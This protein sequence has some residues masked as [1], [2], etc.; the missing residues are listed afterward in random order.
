MSAGPVADDDGPVTGLYGMARLH[1]FRQGDL[2]L[3]LLVRVEDEQLLGV[4]RSHEDATVADG[5]RVRTQTSPE[6]PPRHLPG[7]CDLPQTTDTVRFVGAAVG[8]EEQTRRGAGDDVV[9]VV[10]VQ[11]FDVVQ[12]LEGLRVKDVDDVG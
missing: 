1:A 12:P 11:H 6:Q 2:L 9:R 5:E 10:H 8:H 4:E 3:E 7:R